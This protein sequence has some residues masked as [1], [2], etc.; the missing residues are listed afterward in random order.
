MRYLTLALAVLFVVGMATVADA[1]VGGKADKPAKGDVVKGKVV[2]VAA[3][4][5][6]LVVKNKKAGEVTVKVD[7]Q[8][9]VKGAATTVAA[10]T[11]GEHV[12]VRLAGGVAKV[13]TVKAKGH[14]A[15]KGGKGNTAV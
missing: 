15:G 6:S 13:I 10:I 8:T 3:D 9:Q 7:A 12:V 5:S 2:S 4:G 1:R 11:S 14:K